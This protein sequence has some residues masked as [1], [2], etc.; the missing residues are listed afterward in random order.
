MMWKLLIDTLLQ[1]LGITQAPWWNALPES[2]RRQYEISSLLADRPDELHLHK[3]A[4]QLGLDLNTVFDLFLQ[5]AIRLAKFQ[6]PLFHPR[7]L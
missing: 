1:R 6:S 7:N 3:M 2:Y 4:L 5:L